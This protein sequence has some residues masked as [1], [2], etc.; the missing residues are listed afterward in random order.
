MSLLW[1]TSSCRSSFN[2]LNSKS[3]SC[4]DARALVHWRRHRGRPRSPRFCCWRFNTSNSRFCFWMTVERLHQASHWC[5]FV[6]ARRPL[7]L[8]FSALMSSRASCNFAHALFNG[9]RHSRPPAL[10][11]LLQPAFH[12]LEPEVLLS[13]SPLRMQVPNLQLKCLIR[14]ST[15]TLAVM[16]AAL[17]VFRDTRKSHARDRL[18]EL[19]ASSR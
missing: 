10:F 5:H 8:I 14:E 17:G 15:G 2:A 16:G 13:A 9:R 3:S 11:S 6:G 12:Y 1:S 4:K 19:M 7:P 18:N